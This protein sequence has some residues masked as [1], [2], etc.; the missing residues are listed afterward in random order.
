MFTACSLLYGEHRFDDTKLHF[1]V[2]HFSV[3]A[4]VQANITLSQTFCR[5]DN[6]SGWIATNIHGEQIVFETH[7]VQL[8][9][10]FAPNPC[11]MRFKQQI[12]KPTSTRSVLTASIASFRVRSTTKVNAPT[13]ARFI[14]STP[15]ISKRP[16]VTLSTPS[17]F[18]F[19][20]MKKALINYVW[21]PAGT[22]ATCCSSRAMRAITVR[23]KS[24]RLQW[25]KRLAP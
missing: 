18:Q 7:F 24:P 23:R 1:S 6:T 11:Q 14:W 9:K 5:Y 16:I 15:I 10:F 21:L 4:F 8:L 25:I 2:F 12:Q 17:L 3:F 22:S 13:T 19:I 20:S